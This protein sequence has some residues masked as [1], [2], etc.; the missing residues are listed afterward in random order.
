MASG[1]RELL[2]GCASGRELVERG[3]AEDVALAG[4][5]DVSTAAAELRDGAFV[6]ATLE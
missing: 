1:L 4:A 6:R 5:L 3:F 2:L